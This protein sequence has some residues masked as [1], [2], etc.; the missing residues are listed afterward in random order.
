MHSIVN[1]RPAIDYSNGADGTRVHMLHGAPSTHV[2]VHE[3]LI[4]CVARTQEKSTIC[5]AVMYIH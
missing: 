2:W 4:Q 1:G 3:V 5:D